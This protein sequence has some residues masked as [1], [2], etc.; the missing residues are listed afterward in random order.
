MGTPCAWGAKVG[1]RYCLHHILLIHKHW[2]PAR[3]AKQGPA[4]PQGVQGRV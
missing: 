2:S 3:A 1:G 4:K